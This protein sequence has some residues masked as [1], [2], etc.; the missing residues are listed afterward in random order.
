M[1][2][3]ILSYYYKNGTASSKSFNNTV[4]TKIHV[5]PK[6]RAHPT[7]HSKEDEM[8]R[9]DV[10]IAISI[11]DGL[12]HKPLTSSWNNSFPYM[13]SVRTSIFLPHCLI[14]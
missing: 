8:M 2:S 9:R 4:L 1:Y 3:G 14:T 7:A 11:Q 5:Q 10:S 12:F 13:F 6:H